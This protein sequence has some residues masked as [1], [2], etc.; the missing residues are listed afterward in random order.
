MRTWNKVK[1]GLG[2]LLAVMVVLGVL[3]LAAVSLLNRTN[4][5]PTFVLGH[6]LLWVQTGSMEPA[7]PE[8]S[9]ILVKKLGQEPIEKGTII[10]FYCTDPS[11][12]VYGSLVTHRVSEVTAE[13]YRTKGDNTNPDTWLVDREDI[14][15]V[16]RCNLPFLTAC[17]RVFASPVGLM[18]I[19]AVFI[20]SWA[21]IYIP[22]L[23]RAVKDGSRDD[24]AEKEALMA[25]R[26]RQEVE[27]LRQQDKR[28]DE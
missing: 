5:Q 17:G 6:T 2:I 26:V 16:H 7:I 14:L 9:Y 25:E 1:K 19:L 10:T 15:A 22:D 28:G 18:L 13:G 8:K 12:A 11:S 3:L 20:G 4:G 21:F 24:Q 27:K 23:I